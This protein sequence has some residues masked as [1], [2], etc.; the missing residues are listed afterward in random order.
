MVLINTRYDG[1]GTMSYITSARLAKGSIHSVRVVNTGEGY[2]KIPTVYGVQPTAVNEASVD[3]VWDSVSQTVVG[4]NITN[5]GDGY[6]DPVLLL[7]DTDGIK[8]EYKCSQQ[9]GKLTQV[10]VVK[11][12]SGF[13]YK[14]TAKIIE[15]DVKI[16]LESTNIGL[17][18][19]VKINNPG[20]GFNADKSQLGSYE[21]LLRLS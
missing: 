21:S 11:Q 19:N 17:P 1:T 5:S 14:P 20:R 7:T 9:D 15:A 16:Y 13:T 8:Y 2:A 4:F 18:Q 12:G 6:S 10:E 3:P